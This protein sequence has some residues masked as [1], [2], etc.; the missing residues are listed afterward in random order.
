L[1][2]AGYISPLVLGIYLA[3]SILTYIVYAADKSAAQQML[4]HKSRKEDFRFVFWLTIVLNGGF[5]LW[6]CTD[7]GAD[8]F[9]S[10]IS[11]IG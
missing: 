8:F 6:L 5:Y 11:A 10:L 7:S 2:L 3:A 9:Q 4:R 1:L